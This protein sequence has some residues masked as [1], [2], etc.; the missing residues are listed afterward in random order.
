VFDNGDGVIRTGE[1]RAQGDTVLFHSYAGADMRGGTIIADKL[2]CAQTKQTGGA[3]PYPQFFL[4]CGAVA[5]SGFETGDWNGEGV[6]VIGPGGLAF[7]DGST[8]YA[9]SEYEVKVGQNLGG[10]PAAT[11]Y[12]FADWKLHARP[13]GGQAMGVFA[14]NGSFLVIDTSHYT[15]G[16]PEYDSATSHTVTLDG[17]IGGGGAIRVVGNGKVVFNSASTFS[18]GLTVSN[19]ATVAVNAGCKPGNGAV[20]V[21]SGGT[22]A[23]PQSDEVTIPGAVTLQGGSILSFNFTSADT[24][25]KFI[26]SGNATAASGTVNVEVSAANG[27]YPRNLDGKWLIATNVSGSFELVDPP[28]WAESVSVEDGN[29]YLNVK[30]PGLSLS[31]R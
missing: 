22:L 10:R 17:I 8:L 11:L 16:E 25:P 26:F 6:W 30:T 20:L 1:V 12:S 5:G 27:V 15:I 7:G 31:V 13:G 18:G 21:T 2:T 14:D 28:S 19:A 4:N 9:G 23:V 29:L 24:Q 3:F